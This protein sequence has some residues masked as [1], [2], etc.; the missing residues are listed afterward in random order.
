MVHL[1]RGLALGGLR[2]TFPPL[3]LSPSQGASDDI[4]SPALSDTGD[5]CLPLVSSSLKWGRGGDPPE[6]IWK[7]H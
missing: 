7:E 4:P 5:C 3:V 1:A 2:G 6:R